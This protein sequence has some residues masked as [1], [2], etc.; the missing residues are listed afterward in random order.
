MSTFERYDSVSTNFDK[1][2]VP[3][4]VKV[5]VGGLITCGTPLARMRLLDAGCGTGAYASA[6]IN[7]VGHI[8]AIDISPAML[9]VAR[10]KLREDER[11][12]R[13]AF[14]GGTIEALPFADGCF[15]AI[16]VNQVLHHL[17][18]GRDADCPAHRRV[19]KELFRVLRAGGAAVINATSHTQV[20]QGFWYYDLIPGA[21]EAI[22]RR[23][24]P[25]DRLGE[26]L[27]EC[28]FAVES[29]VVPQ[30]EV[31]QGRAYFDPR[32]PL[33]PDWRQGDSIWAL[34]TPEEIAA[35]EG[36]V[37]Q[38]DA[39]GRLEAHFAECDVRRRGV[40]QFTFFVASKPE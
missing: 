5:I 18:S 25:C 16:M 3:I 24:I 13:I 6:L 39:E 8:D 28:G 35:A 12:G 4:G 7:H 10:E 2:R 33:R 31:M 19:L 17:E 36:R 32:G 14:L 20:R 15:D 1:M 40:G 38:L 23:L 9:A 21:V 37:R 30:D 34:A 29:R 22:L 26:T 27:G 11:A